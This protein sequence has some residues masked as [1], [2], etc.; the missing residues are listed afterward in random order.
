[1]T[2]FLKRILSARIERVAPENF[3]IS[4]GMEFYGDL[5]ARSSSGRIDGRF[6]GQIIECRRIIVGPD[7][8]I[9]GNVF[10]E[11]I[12]LYGYCEGNL[13]ASGD[14]KVFDTAV[15]LGDIHA[16]S[17]LV[18]KESTFRGN[19]RKLKPE[20]MAEFA[21]KEKEKIIKQG[22]SNV[23]NIYS[24]KARREAEEVKARK[25]A[26]GGMEDAADAGNRP[27]MMRVDL[28]QQTGEASSVQV[29]DNAPVQEVLPK[30]NPERRASS[31]LVV[32][33]DRRWF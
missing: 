6:E 3:F 24:L 18:E 15:M 14:V 19:M 27:A 11:D 13:Y 4:T 23:H 28:S 16:S 31:D 17:V 2:S 30:S 26:N 20:D 33:S 21:T 9:K 29:P 22:R 8:I 7:A 10:A 32:E 12:L 1:M 5:V 25:V